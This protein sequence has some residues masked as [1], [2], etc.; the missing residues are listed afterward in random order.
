MADESF[1]LGPPTKEA[2]FE[3]RCPM[4]GG[5]IGMGEIITWNEDY[6]LWICD[7]CSDD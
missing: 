5:H 6:G 3:S 2:E 7:G 4:C 1:M